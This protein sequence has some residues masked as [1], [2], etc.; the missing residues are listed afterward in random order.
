MASP[1]D[2]RPQ[3]SS[4][5]TKD[6]AR[7][8]VRAFELPQALEFFAPLIGAITLD[9]FDTLLWRQTGKP[10]DVFFDLA[11]TPAARA[12]GMTAFD[13]MTAETSARQF[14]RVRSRT[15]EVKLADIYHAD[16]LQLPMTEAQRSALITAEL[17]AEEQACFAFPPFV[18]LVRGAHAKGLKVYIVSD[19]YLSEPQLRHLLS[20][21]LPAGVLEMIDGIFCS[22]EYRRGKTAGLFQD[23]LAKT[24]FKPSELLHIGDN[25]LADF[26]G[27]RAAKIQ[28]LHFIQQDAYIEQ[29]LRTEA[30]AYSMQSGQAR[31]SDSL[32]SPFR[33][34]L[35]AS[36][37][38]ADPP[39]VLGYVGIGPLL[40]SFGKFILDE[41]AQLRAEGKKVKPVFLL[42]DA[43]L[44]LKVC[45]AIAGEEVG[46]AVSISRFSA[47]AAAFRSQHE[48][49]E[50]LTR[51]AHNRFE[52]LAKQLQI[53]GPL[54][55]EII[56]KAERHEQP[57]EEFA[58]QMRK[59]EVLKVIISRSRTHRERLFRHINSRMPMERGDTIVFVDLGYVGTVQR[60]LEPVFREELGIEI[61][62]RYMIAAPTQGWSRARKGLVDGSIVDTR[63]IAAILRNHTIAM[64]E[65]LCTT[66]MVSVTQYEENGEPVV[67]QNEISS[68]QHAR[69]EPIQQHC[70]QFARDAEEFF[71]KIGRHPSM[72]ALRATALGALTRILYFTSEMEV[73]CLEGFR[74]DLNLATKDTFAL[75]DREQGL[76][77]L[78]RRG[79]F[80]MLDKTDNMRTNYPTELRSAS[81]TLSLSLLA[82]NRYSLEFNQH[83][84]T[85][86]H[87]KLRVLFILGNDTTSKDFDAIATYD[88]YYALVV[89]LS[90][91][92]IHLGIAFG[93][94][95]SWVQ[96]ESVEAVRT[97]YLHS[98]KESIFAKDI[99]ADV[100]FDGM[101]ERGPGVFECT[102]ASG[103]M[104]P[105]PPK[106]S[107]MPKLV[108]EKAATSM[109]CRIVFRPLAKRG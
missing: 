70:I 53:P 8:T 21:T 105:T 72:T 55:K 102:T 68:A 27:P 6:P 31:G 1:S 76:L 100:K 90:D 78:Q 108:H 92:T 86:R 84:L 109:V 60:L 48:V 95:Y 87:E 51:N 38:P 23:V 103:F 39:R 43:Y 65:D 98:E 85:L 93:A 50:Y 96:I 2:S 30:L 94:R 73:A 37:Q 75:F 106:L 14:A 33:A 20:V 99:R 13:R 101:V 91:G 66:D 41:L 54:A 42:R 56:R 104:M 7:T 32:Q 67:E 3:Q 24:G 62:G 44:P 59:P 77:G 97:D 29:I 18:E 107:E 26:D 63:A 35:A 46:P 36:P 79:L 34:L 71:R 58:R 5:P 57:S 82:A 16:H 45:N 4:S 83:D 88:G 52:P 47:Q 40:Y 74:I 15:V 9:C 49:D 12:V 64:I 69:L 81:L 11:K 17:A 25:L 80:S 89:P 22:S 28:A 61:V 19:T 10:I